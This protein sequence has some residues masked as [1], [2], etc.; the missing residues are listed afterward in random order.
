VNLFPFHLHGIF[1]KHRRFA[2]YIK[3]ASYERWFDTENC[4]ICYIDKI[5]KDSILSIEIYELEI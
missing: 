1:G 3:F 5:D 2:Y 4:F